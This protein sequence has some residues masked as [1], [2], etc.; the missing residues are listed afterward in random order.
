MG[1]A[2]Q[3]TQRRDGASPGARG[4]SYGPLR[5]ADA[6][7][8]AVFSG[9]LSGAIWP[10]DTGPGVHALLPGAQVSQRPLGLALAVGLSAREPLEKR[11]YPRGG[12]SPYRRIPCAKGCEGCGAQR[13]DR[14]A[15]HMP[16]S[17][18][19]RSLS[20]ICAGP[21]TCSKRVTISAPSRSCSAIKTSLPP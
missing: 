8:A 6:Q 5:H 4:E 16:Y 19:F 12:P 7:R 15:S 2:E 13:R 14:Q 11:E 1:S 21:R 18:A 17:P 20:R 3:K 10:M 9:H